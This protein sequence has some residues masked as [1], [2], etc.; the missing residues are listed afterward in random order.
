MLCKNPYSPYEG[1]YVG[2]G[3]CLFCRIHGA[4]VWQHRL[5]LEESVWELSCFATLTY[6]EMREPYDRSVNP[7]ELVNF[8]KRLRR[9]MEPLKVRFYGV[10]EYGEES[11]RPHYHV[12]LFGVGKEIAYCEEMKSNRF[13]SP[14]S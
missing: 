10:G 13:F 12:C 9:R 14:G 11:G 5:M 3:R 2:C 4:R 6:D 1:T 8:M 7:K